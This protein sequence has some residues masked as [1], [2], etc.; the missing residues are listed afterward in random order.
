MK[1]LVDDELTEYRAILEEVSAGTRSTGERAAHLQRLLADA[2]QAG[3]PWAT[4]ALDDAQL[5]GLAKTVK[6]HMKA[7]SVVT[8]KKAER[9]GVIGVR[10]NVNGTEQWHQVP[11][12][13]VTWDELESSTRLAKSNAKALSITVRI[14][15]KLLKL[16]ED[17]PTTR[18]IGEALAAVG[19]SLDEYLAA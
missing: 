2:E 6:A 15:Q 3:R 16:R 4:A 1:H 9:S 13:D 19:Q 17:H 8:I 18:T 14:Q 5:A 11:L 10:R 7:S 12:G